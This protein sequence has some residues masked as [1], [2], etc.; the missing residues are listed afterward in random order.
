MARICS[1]GLQTVRGWVLRFN[2]ARPD[3]L[4]DGKAPGQTPKLDEAQRQAFVRIV[5]S[6]PIATLPGFKGSVY[7]FPDTR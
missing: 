3:G 7:S 2:A 5:D 4:V 6:V 1:V